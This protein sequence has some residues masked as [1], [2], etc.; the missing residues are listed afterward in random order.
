[1]STARTRSLLLVVLST[2]FVSVPAPSQ[3]APSCEG[4]AATIVGTAGDDEIRGT[5]GPDVIV[6]RGGDD[7]VEARGGDD[8]VCGG[9]GSDSLRGGRGDDDLVGG[10]GDDGLLGETGRDRLSGG[11][12]VDSLSGGDD[13]DR[14]Y[15]GKGTFN[16]LSGDQGDDDLNGGPG[17]GDV[18]DFGLNGSGVTVDL[19]AG[20]IGGQGSDTISGVENVFGSRYD[21]TLIGDDRPNALAGRGG[22]DTVSSGGGGSLE[23]EDPLAGISS[24][25]CADILLGEAGDDT[26]TGGD[27]LDVVMYFDA[28]DPVTVDLAAGTA[29]GEGSDTLEGIE[30]VHGSRNGDSLTGGADDNVFALEGGDDTVVGAG[31]TDLVLYAETGGVAVDLTAGT[32]EG[33]G[34][35]SL[36]GIEDVWGSPGDDTLIGDGAANELRGRGGDD[37]I[38]GGAGEDDLSGGAGTDSLDGGGGFD[39][40][41]GGE[42][43]TSCEST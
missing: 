43:L 38:S 35:D 13:D 32:A 30:G 39:T 29:T 31:G 3:A 26:L 2:A 20:T 1:M 33:A 22:N 9:G 15:A 34:A 27:G 25:S 17:R 7:S 42:T 5:N 18:V 11:G 41:T 8:I 10:A 23:C 28:P 14:L 6:A 21:D 36:S 24:F 16:F 4:R 19:G 12:G 37:T 40:C